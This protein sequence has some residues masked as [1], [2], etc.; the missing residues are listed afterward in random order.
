M[1]GQFCP[2]CDEPAT[3]DSRFCS[4]HRAQAALFSQSFAPDPASQKPG[5]PRAL[6]SHPDY[7]WLA[8]AVETTLE[9]LKQRPEGEK[10]V[11]EIAVY[12][13]RGKLLARPYFSATQE[14][15][16]RAAADGPVHAA[17]APGGEVF[18]AFAQAFIERLE[19]LKKGDL[20][21]L[22]ID[23]SPQADVI[24]VSARYADRPRQVLRRF[25][26]DGTQF[27]E[28]PET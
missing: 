8:A 22:A 2:I 27:V 26:R 6:D 20:M 11:P 12:C 25:V 4:R 21:A 14:P 16:K 9:Q 7:A 3:D 28:K 17:L 24:A 1:K 18:D 15:A 13:L 5:A 23:F 19:R 10:R